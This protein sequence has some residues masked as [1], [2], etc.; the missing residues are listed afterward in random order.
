MTEYKSIPHEGP[1]F[2]AMMREIDARLGREGYSIED[3]PIFAGREVSV[4]HGVPIPIGGGDSERMPPELAAY[5]PLAAPPRS[6][7]HTS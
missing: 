1:L 6:F 2:D 7:G 3:R 5:A 4:L